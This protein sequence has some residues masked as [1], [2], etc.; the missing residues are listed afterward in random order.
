MRIAAAIMTAVVASM[1]L[2][3]LAVSL[4][5]DVPVSTWVAVMTVTGLLAVMLARALLMVRRHRDAYVTSISHLFVRRPPESE[6]EEF[7]RAFFRDC[8]IAVERR[9]IDGFPRYGNGRVSV[10]I[11]SAGRLPGVGGLT[12]KDHTGR[13]VWLLRAFHRAATE[14]F[15]LD[16]HV[17][18]AKRIG[19]RRTRR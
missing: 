4:Q 18:N 19:P 8:G 15:G 10:V 5:R 2:A 12:M 11:L 1:P 6:V 9:E 17:R 7:V 14:R 16:P 3:L 13:N